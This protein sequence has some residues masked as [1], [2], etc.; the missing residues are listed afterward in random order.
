MLYVMAYSA[1]LCGG[2]FFN[3]ESYSVIHYR[4]C[5]TFLPKFFYTIFRKDIIVENYIVQTAI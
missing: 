4:M 5:N 3:T 2:N 1:T